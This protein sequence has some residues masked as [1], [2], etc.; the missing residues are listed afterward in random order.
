MGS[1]NP[2]LSMISRV[3]VLLS[4]LACTTAQL[5]NTV[6]NPIKRDEG[7]G[8]WNVSRVERG[9]NGRNG[10]L[11]PVTQ[12]AAHP[13]PG[14]FY[15][16]DSYVMQYSVRKGRKPDVIYFW[17]GSKSSRWEKG[18]SAILTVD[19]DNKN[20]G[21]AKQARVD[22]NQEPEHFL[23]IFNGTFVTLMGGVEREEVEQDKDGV[24][25]F[26]VRAE[27]N[28]VGDKKP[29]VRTNQVEEKKTNINN[30]DVFIL[31]T[32]KKLF[33]FVGKNASPEEKVTAIKC[34]KSLFPKKSPDVSEGAQ[35]S[36]EFLA[37]LKP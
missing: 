6:Q 9:S 27:C 3:S 5:C 4:I 20:G 1:T 22:M 33:M 35:P 15:E 29:L 14:T 24:M 37:S 30:E 36:K 21:V 18:A 7:E 10:R 25:L 23:N 19:L 17:Q 8:P 32:P 13:L 16:G 11:V 26:R 34:A 31:D 28:S 2:A 12:G